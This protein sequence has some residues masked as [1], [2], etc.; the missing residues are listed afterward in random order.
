MEIRS[1][2]AFELPPDIK[3]VVERTSSELSRSDL[4]VR[5]V[6]PGNI[7]LTI[8]FLGN[9]KEEAVEEVGARAKKVCKEFA[10]FA[11]SLE[12]MGCFPNN[13]SPRV[14]WLGL[15]GDL[16]KMSRFRDSLQAELKPLGVKQEKRPFKPHLTLGRF[17]K[18]KKANSTLEK[19]LSDYSDL[20]S[21]VCSLNELVLFRSDL[22]P[23]GAVYTKLLAFP[24]SG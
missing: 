14:L 24:L 4:D 12:G 10:P 2:L 8:I 18:V 17:R 5:W 1:F 19:L 20:K 3:S 6:K 16:E 11:I 9:I 22:R 21:P 23:G 7:H 13:R 15:E